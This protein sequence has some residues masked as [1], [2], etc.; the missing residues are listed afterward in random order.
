MQ[1]R[2]FIVLF[3]NRVNLYLL[4]IEA[5]H[6]VQYPLH[7]PHHSD[8]GLFL[9]LGPIPAQIYFYQA[10]IFEARRL[11]H[12]C[13]QPFPNSNLTFY[14]NTRVAYQSKFVCNVTHIKANTASACCSS[15]AYSCLPGSLGEHFIGMNKCFVI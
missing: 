8:Y 15:G 6:K 3:S 2:N 4:L 5:I 9:Y 13:K 11:L 1:K 14:R 10:H 7:N 12:H